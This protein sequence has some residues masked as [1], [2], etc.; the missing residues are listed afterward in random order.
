MSIQGIRAD[1]LMKK[2]IA[3]L[4]F[5]V[6]CYIPQGVSILAGKPKMGKSFLRFSWPL[7]LRLGP[8]SACKPFSLVTCFILLWRTQSGEFKTV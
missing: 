8:T 7:Q 1:D 2:D 6:P 3:P 4:Q 5:A